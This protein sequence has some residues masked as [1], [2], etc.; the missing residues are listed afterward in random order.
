[1]QIACIRFQFSSATP[2]LAEQYLSDSIRT[3]AKVELD[4]NVTL[5]GDEEGAYSGLGVVQRHGRVGELACVVGLVAVVN[6]GEGLSEGKALR[7]WESHLRQSW[8]VGTI[9]L[10]KLQAWAAREHHGRY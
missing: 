5:G 2:E 3:K 7:H 9:C 8:E 1:M 10:R 6:E 4:L